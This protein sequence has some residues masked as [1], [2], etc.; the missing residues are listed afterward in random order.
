MTSRSLP[1]SM[2]TIPMIGYSFRYEASI[3]MQLDCDE[4]AVTK[5]KLLENKFKD[6][7]S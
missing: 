2:I 6:I 1:M 3:R 7:V 5:E 4:Y